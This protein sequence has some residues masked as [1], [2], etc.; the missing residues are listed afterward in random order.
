MSLIEIHC[1]KEIVIF[2]HWQLRIDTEENQI[3]G[4]LL[5]F[6]IVIILSKQYLYYGHFYRV[7]SL[8]MICQ[9]PDFRSFYRTELQAVQCKN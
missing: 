9:L 7:F 3:F 4:R 8:Q 5:D 1:G 6:I 2:R